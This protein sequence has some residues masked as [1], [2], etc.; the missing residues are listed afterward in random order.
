MLNEERPSFPLV[1]I[2]AIYLLSLLLAM[3]S[4]G[5]PFPFMGRFYTGLAGEAFVFADSICSLYLLI[6]II[7][8]QR[9]TVWLVIAYNLLD[10][11]N[12]WVNLALLS[13]DDYAAV[14][15]VPVSADAIRS[16][17][18]FIALFLVFVTI[19]VFAKRR[20]FTNP[21]PYLF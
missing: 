20:H 8:R 17:T 2:A 18:V 9:L 13:A 4:Y 7:R 15:G 14:A 10:I 19:Y 11:G 1:A 5:E 21:S 12:A 16:D 3:S 6:G